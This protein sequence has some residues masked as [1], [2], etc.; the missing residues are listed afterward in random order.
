MVYNKVKE[1]VEMV[2]NQGKTVLLV[3]LIVISLALAG[4]GFYLLQQERAKNL[5]LQEELEDLKTKQRVAETKLEEYKKDVARLDVQVQEA[6]NQVGTLGEELKREKAAKEESLNQIEQL[7]VE[8]DQ[9]KGLRQDL[10]KKFTQAQADAKKVQAQV[11]DLESQRTTLEAK[12]NELETKA[13]AEEQNNVEL[14]TIVVSPE[15]AAAEGKAAIPVSSVPAKKTAITSLQSIQEGKVLVVNKEYNFA[16]ISLGLKDG[17][18]V[19]NVFSVYRAGK[20]YIGDI[21][22][23][24]VHDS[25]AAAGFVTGSIKNKISENDTVR[26]KK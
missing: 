22:I 9:Q 6:R 5:S 14:G 24:K 13:Q 10:E 20:K 26:R 19:G 11:R 8:L 17:V 16:V 15:A 25:M 12:V 2:R 18:D 21:K 23:E 4:G 7:R 1:E 3:I